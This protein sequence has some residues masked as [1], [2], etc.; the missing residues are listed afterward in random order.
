MDF[1]RPLH[2]VTPTLD[3]DVFAALSGGEIEVSG[4]ELHRLV[5]HSSKKASGRP[6][7]DSYAKAS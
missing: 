5:G 1:R 4:R 2:V 3:G 7:T 6:P